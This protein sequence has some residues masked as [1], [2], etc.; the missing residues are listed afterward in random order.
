[1]Y[2]VNN[3]T[4]QVGAGALTL[5][6]GDVMRW[7][8]TLYGY[9]CDLGLADSCW[10]SESYFSQVDKT[11]L[12]RGIGKGKTAT[13]TDAELATARTTAVNPAATQQQV[14]AALTALNTAEPT[15]AWVRLTTT[16]QGQP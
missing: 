7:Q 14:T 3:V 15:S 10:E 5:H 9:G 13:A 6:D 2:T 4:A 1:M 11:D 8:F 12:I 16:A